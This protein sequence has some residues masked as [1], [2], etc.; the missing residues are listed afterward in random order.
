[1]KLG[2]IGFFFL[3]QLTVGAQIYL[4]LKIVKGVVT[5]EATA[6][7][8]HMTAAVIH[9]RTEQWIDKTFLSEPVITQNIPSRISARFYQEYSSGSWSD[10]FQHS[11]QIDI[12]DNKAVFTITDTGLNLVRADGTWKENLSRMRVMLEQAANE[13]FWSY[14][15]SL[16]QN[17]GGK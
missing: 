7:V 12:Q 17:P 14:S 8:D 4:P 9:E 3:I 15:D 13:L 6:E 1:M 2:L 11:L 5:F 16:K 10:S